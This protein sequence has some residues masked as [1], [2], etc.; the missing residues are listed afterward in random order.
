MADPADQSLWV[1]GS[2][3]VDMC[4]RDDKGITQASPGG[5]GPD[6]GYTIT[7][8]GSNAIADHRAGHLRATS[9]PTGYG[10]LCNGT[11]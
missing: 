1:L 8:G 10:R 7:S 4:K 5:T 6:T 11:D 2:V 9:K 3:V